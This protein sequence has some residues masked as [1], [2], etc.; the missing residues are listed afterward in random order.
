MKN[1]SPTSPGRRGMSVT[2]FK[3]V[4][5]KDKPKKSLTSGFRRAVGRNNQGKITTRHKGAG[6]KRR[7]RQIDF[8]YA[9]KDIP[10]KV[11]SIEYDPNRTCFIALICFRDGEYQYRLAPQGLKV[12]DEIIISEKA[13]V[14]TG[15]A[16]KIG[17][18][19]SG[20]MI[21]NI[22]FK[23]GGGGKL[24]RAGGSS[25]EILSHQDKL[26]LIRMPSKEIRNV[27]SDAWATV[28]SLSNEDHRFITYGKAGKSRH[29]GIRP[30]VRGSA[31]NPCDHPY[32][33]GEGRALRGTRRPKNKWGKGTRGVKT[34]KRKKYSN[35]HIIQR[36][37]K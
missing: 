18:L 10:A 34:R 26:T 22:E 27:P 8:G 15:N 3:N 25:A 30:T 31:M 5:T 7:Y 16:L 1:Y 23:P 21:Y 19:S 11:I 36:R 20:T 17:S 28:G 37:K 2:S 4:I 24:V 6:V 33:G 13:P 9:K 35:I 12:S 14:K 29:R 32:G